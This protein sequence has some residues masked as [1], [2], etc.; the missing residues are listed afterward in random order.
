[1][2]YGTAVRTPTKRRFLGSTTPNKTRKLCNATSSM[3]SGTSNST[4]R[5]VFGGTVCRSPV[6]RPPLS[7]SKVPTVR[8]PGGGKPPHPK[9]QGCN[10]ENQAQLKGSPL[11]GALLTPASP[12][13]NISITSVASTYS[14]FVK[15]N[16]TPAFLF[17][18]RDLSKASNTKVQH[19]I[20]N[21]TTSNH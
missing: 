7:A 6:S 3:S 17:V 20:L 16:L 5:S 15:I 19:N 10:K 4:M 12:Q 21:S 1:M 18:Q 11:S 14:E 13:R 8:T 2:L 9:L